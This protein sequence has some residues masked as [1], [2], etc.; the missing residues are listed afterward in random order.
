MGA[1]L[2]I[3]EVDVRRPDDAIQI[4]RRR[5]VI[6]CVLRIA[7]EGWNALGLFGDFDAAPVFCV[8]PKSQRPKAD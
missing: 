7:A 4:L 3:V 6:R 8:G 5:L 2:G 1:G